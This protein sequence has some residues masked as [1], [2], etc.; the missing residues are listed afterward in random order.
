MRYCKIIIITIIAAVNLLGNDL[1]GK[2]KCLIKGDLTSKSYAESVMIELKPP[3]LVK[4]FYIIKIS[5]ITDFSKYIMVLT[6]DQIRIYK[7]VMEGENIYGKLFDLEE[8]CELLG[9]PF[10]MKDI[11]PIKWEHY[12]LD[13]KKFNIEHEKFLMSINKYYNIIK[14]KYKKLVNGADTYISSARDCL[15]IYENNK[16]YILIRSKQDEGEDNP[17]L[18]WAKEIENIASRK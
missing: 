3:E 5:I 12:D 17:M 15:I 4:K 6:E 14:N 8:K 9:D 16:E 2:E 13:I 1:N 10:N 18:K 7:Y 11:L